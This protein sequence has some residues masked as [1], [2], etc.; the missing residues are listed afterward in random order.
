MMMKM[1]MKQRGSV[2]KRENKKMR[3]ERSRKAGGRISCSGNATREMGAHDTT[4]TMRRKMRQGENRRRMVACQ[5]VKKKLDV[6]QATGNEKTRT[7]SLTH[8]H[9]HVWIRR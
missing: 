4:T 7:H 6:R 2:R 3:I 8:T 9:T 5:A 1:M